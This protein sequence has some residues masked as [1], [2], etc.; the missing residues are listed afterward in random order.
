VLFERER[1]R[2]RKVV[3]AKSLF[4]HAPLHQVQRL[5]TCV[6]ASS[7]R[8]PVFACRPGE[9]SFGHGNFIKDES[10]ETDLGETAEKKVA[11]LALDTRAWIRWWLFDGPHLP[12]TP[13]LDT[14]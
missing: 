5:S 2:S 1:R 12:A 9:R 11:R 13:V 6:G 8:L 4:S 7:R 3:V 14:A 10:A